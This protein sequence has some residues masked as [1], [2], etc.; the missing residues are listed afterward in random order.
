MSAP[1][2][3]DTAD[4]TCW[5]RRHV[6]RD[7]LALYAPEGV[8]QCPEFVMATLPELAEHGIVRVADVLPVP[9]GLEPQALPLPVE[10]TEAQIEALVAAGDRVVNDEM[11]QRLCMC[12][13]WPKACV[14]MGNYFMGAWDVSGLET[15][16]PA[17]LGLWE[18]MR[19]GEML[20]LRARVAA[21]LEER[22][23]A[24]E[25][26]SDA[27][28]QLRVNRDRI[29]ALEA[30]LAEGEQPADE[31]PIAYVLTEKAEEPADK[32]TRLIAPVQALR[33]DD[34]YESPLHHDY[35][36]SHDL[37]QTGGSA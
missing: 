8:C 4:G 22:R 26:L 32:P 5:T 35:L 25:S 17:V 34:G 31:D 23:S 21:L 19:G 36:V 14:S 11:H 15:A 3:V 27:A 13:E 28:E 29:A 2:V 33:E 6:T 10:L 37:P 24:N 16:I 7:G 12:D 18:Q 9:V 30:D 20:A 1:L